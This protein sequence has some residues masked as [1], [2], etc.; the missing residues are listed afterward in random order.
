MRTQRIFKKTKV[1]V[2]SG[3]ITELEVDAIVNPANSQLLMGGGVA[4]AILRAGGEQ[5]QGEALQ[6]APVP[7]GKAVATTAGKL[8]A[9]YVIHA[10]TM[11]RPAMPI[12]KENAGHATKAAL[13]CAEQLNIKSIAFPGLGT[14]VGGLKAAEAA[15]V[16]VQEIKRYIEACTSINRIVLVGFDADLT[17]AFKR[18][19]EALLRLQ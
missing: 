18:E 19:I 7:I 5:I 13:E 8:K 15:Q 17:Q 11:T 1:E 6:K 14:G 12:G 10:P 2:I 9:K 4:G 16:M 3:D